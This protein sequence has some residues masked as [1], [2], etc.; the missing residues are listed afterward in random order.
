MSYCSVTSNVTALLACLKLDSVISTPRQFNNLTR[1][2]SD[3][4]EFEK[5]IRL[6]CEGAINLVGNVNELQIG[7]G[8]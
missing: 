6:D 1:N 8:H 5:K 3:G 7:E 2:F 4:P